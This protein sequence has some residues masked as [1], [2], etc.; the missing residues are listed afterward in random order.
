MKRLQIVILCLSTS[1]MAQDTLQVK[2]L[3]V[4]GYVKYLQSFTW[5]GNLTELVTGSLVHNRI[6]VKWLPTTRITG[7]IELRNRIFWGEEVASTRGF[8][9]FLRNRNEAVDLSVN[10]IDERRMVFHTN[11]DRLWLEYRA[12]KWNVR[13]G[14]QRINWGI[15]TTWNP[16]DLF[17][18][19]NF[20]DF[21][22]EERPGADAIRF[23][24]PTGAMS[25]LEFALSVSEQH[26]QEIGAVRYFTNVR[27]YDLQFIAGWFLEQ[28]TVGVGWS[29]SIRETGFKGELQYFFERSGYTDQLNLS[30]EADHVLGE[31]WY[32]G[33]GLLLNN[34]GVTAFPPFWN[35]AALELSPRNLMPTK[36]NTMVTVTKEFTPLFSSAITLVYAPG[37][38]LTM[39]LP[40]AT[41]SITQNVDLYFVWQS[42][43]AEGRAG[44][45]DL[46]HRG[47]LRLKWSF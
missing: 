18:T 10:W 27:N 15:G 33:G 30:I 14:R 22:Y 29:G 24:Y 41:Y 39:V 37:T 12:E 31:S 9:S 44:F 45:D 26:R 13:L 35:A 17:N 11:I 40:S 20:L 46:S 7:A 25:H 5:Q 6:N 21:D 43:F 23:Q 28:P 3:Q 42:F 1:A 19:F 4:A 32:L 34:L 2:R 38:E 36:W 8:S 16:N 47:F